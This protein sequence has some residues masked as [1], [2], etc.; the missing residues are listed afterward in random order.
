MERDRGR[1]RSA[2]RLQGGDDA[3]AA[4]V[5]MESVDVILAVEHRS[6]QR[7]EW[8]RRKCVLGYLYLWDGKSPDDFGQLV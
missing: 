3:S 4:Q 7:G 6:V 8:T 1:C 2:G 5:L